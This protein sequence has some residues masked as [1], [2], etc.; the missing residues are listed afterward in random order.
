MNLCL[1]NSS[2]SVDS[3]RTFTDAF[4]TSV[5]TIPY[6]GGVLPSE[7]D[8][9]SLPDGVYQFC[10]SRTES[11]AGEDCIL[12]TKAGQ[13][14]IVINGRCNQPPTAAFPLGSAMQC[15]VAHTVTVIVGDPDGDALTATWSVDGTVYG[16]PHSLAA[17]ATSDSITKVFGFGQHTVHVSVDDGAGGTTTADVTILVQDNEPPTITGCPANITVQTGPGRTTCDQVV[18]WT[19]PTA[20]DNCTVASFTSD[21]LPG[22]TFPVGTTTVTCTA[23]DGADNQAVCTFTVTVEDTTPPVITT[24]LAAVSV[25]FASEPAAATTVAEFMDQGG[26]VSDNCG[27]NP[28]VTSSDSVAGLCPTI[29]TR[30]Y[31]ITD[32]SDNTTTCDQIITVNN[33]F[34]ADGI[35]WHQPLARSGMSED[36]DPGAGNTLKYRF[37]LGS[38]IPI[39]VHGLGCST[40]VTANNNVIGK[41]EVFGDTDMDGVADGNALPIDYNGVGEPGGLMDKIDGHLKYNVDT[42]KL[43][44]QTSKCYILQVTI[45]DSSTGES[46]VETVPLQA[47]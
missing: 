10:V 32:T 3:S 25:P 6:S 17:G 37:K 43:P 36:T 16:T 14:R 24:C 44:V 22:D 9:S 12:F 31:T 23:T 26:A 7:I 21:H 18:T 11:P 2:V 15:N 20:S 34:A 4:T 42:K 46:R 35:I 27:L 41:V 28:V 30:T 1:P 33:L 40:D 45:T 47:K 19:P 13:D 5:L 38:T 8:I 39:K 29:I